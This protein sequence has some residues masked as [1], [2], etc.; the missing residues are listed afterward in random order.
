M[1]KRLR[2]W[3]FLTVATG[4]T[5]FQF[6]FGGCFGGNWWPYNTQVDSWSRILTAIIRED[7]F[8]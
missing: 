4:A 8:S 3:T 1:L 5:L 6:G 7:L 2:M